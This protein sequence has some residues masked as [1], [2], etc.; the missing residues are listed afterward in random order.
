MGTPTRG[1]LAAHLNPQKLG[2]PKNIFSMPP[3]SF[4]TWFK[5][6]K[7]EEVKGL[8]ALVEEGGAFGLFGEGS[9]FGIELRTVPRNTDYVYP[10][11]VTRSGDIDFS[12]PGVLR[13]DCISYLMEQWGGFSMKWTESFKSFAQTFPL[14]EWRI[15]PIVGQPT[16]DII[17]TAVMFTPPGETPRLMVLHRAGWSTFF[18][19]SDPNKGIIGLLGTNLSDL[20]P[21]MKAA[22]EHRIKLKHNESVPFKQELYNAM[23]EASHNFTMA[24]LCTVPEGYVNAYVPHKDLLGYNPKLTAEFEL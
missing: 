15:A 1:S 9:P 8:K 11:L 19:K 16:A 13:F 22:N 10:K 18:N 5:T 17:W 23:L 3:L 24:K 12:W 21:V 14:N 20:T 7:W 6:R 2:R 4:A